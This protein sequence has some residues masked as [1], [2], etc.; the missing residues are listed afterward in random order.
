MNGALPLSRLIEAVGPLDG[1]VER[2]SVEA[3]APVEA[4]S[5]EIFLSV[6]RTATLLLGTPQQPAA[7]AVSDLLTEL[8]PEA[9]PAQAELPVPGVPELTPQVDVGLARLAASLEHQGAT[10]D[11]ELG[12]RE[13]ESATGS[14][15]GLPASTLEALAQQV[16][17]TTT[18]PS[19]EARAPAE[20]GTS[21]NVASGPDGPSPSGENASALQ[22]AA[23]LEQG[24]TSERSAERVPDLAEL[25]DLPDLPDQPDRGRGDDRADDPRLPAAVQQTAVAAAYES[26]AQGGGE[27]RPAATMP[28]DAIPRQQA[29]PVAEPP[30]EGAARTSP[31]DSPPVFD[32][33]SQGS[34]DT[35]R[36]TA[37]PTTTEQSEL[38]TQTGSR[39][40][41]DTNSSSIPQA[42]LVS[43]PQAPSASQDVAPTREPRALPELPVEN[44]T[45]I[46]R[47][48]RLLTQAGGGQA[49]IQLHPPQLGELYLRITVTDQSVSVSFVAEHAQ[50]A[51][52]LA[53]HLPEL[54]QALEGMGLRLDNLELDARTASDE[55]D[56][57][58]SR[59]SATD[60]DTRDGMRRQGLPDPHAD[61]LQPL[62]RVS[63]N[64]LGTVDVTI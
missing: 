15:A 58:G 8:D 43:A 41:Q 55:E 54:R 27:T 25:P 53:R 50:I 59:G 6:L 44:E 22:A 46:I 60:G 32:S 37:R 48:A 9:T 19:R 20:A 52:V 28:P 42:Q 56:R 30:T 62:P 57:F 31:G 2:A 40:T 14:A 1:M 3:P 12:S 24:D 63:P 29:A 35:G 61:V 39:T 49:R 51:D 10:P 45:E 47:E 11:P 26:S 18:G 17:Q 23:G 34:D 5:A 13:D 33:P 16:A 38:G 64:S 36:E 4:E 7:T 21:G